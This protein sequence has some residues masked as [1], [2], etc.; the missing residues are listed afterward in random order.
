MIADRAASQVL[1]APGDQ[2][3]SPARVLN[4]EQDLYMPDKLPAAARSQ[5]GR[6]QLAC[7]WMFGHD[8]RKIYL[9]IWG[10]SFSRWASVSGFSI[11]TCWKV[12]E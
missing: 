7:L 4:S 10:L 2:W 11:R 3:H 12:K 1:I 9:C 6:W 8:N 5:A